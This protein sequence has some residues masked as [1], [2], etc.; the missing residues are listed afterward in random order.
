MEHGSS[1]NT[2]QSQSTVLTADL[3]LRTLTPQIGH[4]VLQALIILH[5]IPNDGVRLQLIEKSVAENCCW[6]FVTR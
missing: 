6:V 2:C 5:S 4:V 3:N 1:C